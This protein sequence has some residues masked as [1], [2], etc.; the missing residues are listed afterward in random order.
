MFPLDA[1]GD[2]PKTSDLKFSMIETTCGPVTTLA[3]SAKRS[4]RAR[5]PWS[6]AN[7]FDAGT[8]SGS[9]RQR[10]VPRNQRRIERFRKSKVSRVVGCQVAPERPD[11]K[12]ENVVWITVQRQIGEIFE[13]LLAP[14]RV[15]FAGEGIAPQDLRN[16]KI[17]HMRGVQCIFAAEQ[18]LSYP[19]G[20][21]CVEQHFEQSGSVDDNHCR[22]RSARTALA[23]GI[24]GVTE[25]R[26]VRRRR[27]SL[28][29]GRSASRS[30]SCSRYSDSESPSIAAR[31][32]SFR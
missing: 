10:G 28:S 25:S 21:G 14:L 23:G 17:E 32:F 30:T 2:E 5:M 31:A 8:V 15:H 20:C 18:P 4:D 9:P 19:T 16:L 6:L 11:S 12:E 1:A 7:D 13:C 24:R 3:Q 22:S 29:V 26:C 27:R